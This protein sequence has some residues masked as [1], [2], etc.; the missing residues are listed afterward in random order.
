MTSKNAFEKRLNN[1]KKAARNFLQT[2]LP[3][4]AEHVRMKSNN[5]REKIGEIWLKIGRITAL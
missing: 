1:I 5:F 3:S 4:L 2:A